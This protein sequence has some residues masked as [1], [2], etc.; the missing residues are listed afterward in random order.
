[1]SAARFLPLL[2]SVLLKSLGF[3]SHGRIFCA[4]DWQPSSSSRGKGEVQHRL[5]ARRGVSPQAFAVLEVSSHHHSGLVPFI[6]PGLRLQCVDR[7]GRDHLHIWILAKEFLGC[8]GSQDCGRVSIEA[9]SIGPF[10]TPCLKHLL[11]PLG[12]GFPQWPVQR[13]STCCCAAAGNRQRCLAYHRLPC[14]LTS[15]VAISTFRLGFL[16]GCLCLRPWL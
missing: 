5:A 13:W 8:S 11:S 14:F 1:M 7:L 10:L 16:L 6:L 12:I 9:G 3:R 4:F 15:V 2:C